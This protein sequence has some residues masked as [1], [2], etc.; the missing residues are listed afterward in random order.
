[1]AAHRASKKH[2]VDLSINDNKLIGE[3]CE[4]Q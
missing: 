1:V 3:Q 2:L 4:T